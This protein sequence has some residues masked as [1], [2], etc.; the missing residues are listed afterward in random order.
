MWRGSFITTLP[1]AI[2]RQ[3]VVNRKSSFVDES[4]SRALTTCWSSVSTSLSVEGC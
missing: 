2:N 1:P 4:A 3:L